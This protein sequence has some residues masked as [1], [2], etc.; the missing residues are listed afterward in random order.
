[1]TSFGRATKKYHRLYSSAPPPNE[2]NDDLDLDNSEYTGDIDWD[3]EW[4]NV[5]KNKDKP[6]QRPGKEFYKSEAEVAA[7]RAANKA[8]EQANKTKS[9]IPEI[10]SFRSVK[11]DWKFWIGVIALVSVGLSVLSASGSGGAPSIS[12][13]DSYYI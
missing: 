1:L 5:V 10:P 6:Q 3:A 4:K 8:A 11:G 7:I 2:G 12:S 9:S 13:P